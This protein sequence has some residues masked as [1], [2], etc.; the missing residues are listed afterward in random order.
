MSF[1]VLCLSAKLKQFLKENL[2]SVNSAITLAHIASL[3]KKL[4]KHFQVKDFLSLEHGNFLEFLV[5]HN[6]VFK[7]Y[8]HLSSV[9][10]N[11]H[12]LLKALGVITLLSRW[13]VQLLQ[14]TLGSA[15]ILSSSSMELGGSGFRPTRQDV[16]EFIKQC[17]D[18]SSTDPD[19]VSHLQA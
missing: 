19:E 17:G 6:Q 2:S 13:S 4:I 8:F 1:L 3:E 11:R 5:K 12:F 18:V 9:C 7:V 16:F 14:D 15:L 10:M